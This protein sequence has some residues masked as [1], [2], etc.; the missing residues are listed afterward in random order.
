MPYCLADHCT[1]TCANVHAANGQKVSVA[2]HEL[3]LEFDT[4]VIDIRKG[5]LTE[6]CIA[7]HPVQ[8]TALALTPNLQDSHIIAALHVHCAK[9][10]RVPYTVY[11][12]GSAL[13]LSAYVYHKCCVL[14]SCSLSCVAFRCCEDCSGTG[15]HMHAGTADK[16]P[17]AH[18]FCCCGIDVLQGTSSL[19]S[20]RRSTPTQRSLHSS[21]QMD[22][23]RK[24][25]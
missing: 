12:T 3:G 2:L 14:A 24:I 18:A 7:R 23:V 5:E 21:T 1:Y 17:P 16:Q 9:H 13:V 11:R 15:G 22:L 4:H 6:P 25:P 20:S 19:T 8:G 10:L